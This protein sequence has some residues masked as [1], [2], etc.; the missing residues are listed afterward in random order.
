MVMNPRKIVFRVDAS[1]EIGTGHVMRCLTL[2]EALRDRGCESTFICR[3]HPGN[4]IDLISERGF[5][6]LGLPAV[7]VTQDLGHELNLPAHA[8]WLGADW[9]TDAAQT[10]MAMGDITADWLVIDHYA[11]DERWERE[12]RPACRRLMVIDDL[13]DRNHD[14]DL[15]LDQNLIEGWQDRYRGNVPENCALLLG[16][17]YALMQPVYSEL[18]DR[19]PPRE[20]PIQRILVYFGG[21]DTDNLT[22]MVISAFETLK[23]EQVSMDVVINPASPHAEPLRKLASRDGRIRL[24]EH[25]PSLAHLMAK[26][27]FAVGAGGA[28]SW[29][30]CCLGLPSI[31]ITLAENQ[32]P[33]AAEL[34]KL[35]LIQWLGHK[36]EVDEHAMAEALK[37]LMKNGLESGWSERCGHAVDGKGTSRVSSI[38][39]V[40][41]KNSLRARPATMDD[42]INVI[43]WSYFLSTCSHASIQNIHHSIE[44]TKKFRKYLRDIDT[45]HVLIVETSSKIPV[46]LIYFSRQETSWSIQIFHA[47]HLGNFIRAEMILEEALR[48]LRENAAGVLIFSGMQNSSMS[49]TTVANRHGQ[50]TNATKQKRLEI[51]VCTD[52]GSWINASVPTLIQGW[53]AEGHSVSWSHDASTLAGG[54]LCFNLSYGRIVDAKTRSRY[55]NNLVVHASDLPKGRG[56]SPASW[57]ILEGAERLPV[58]LLE[59][60]DA[61]DAGPIYLQK[62][63]PL[64]GA[65]LIDDWRELIADATIEL[66]RSFVSRHPEILH[67]AREQTGESSSYPRRRATNS[68]LDPA[69]TLAEQFN[70]LRIVDNEDYPAFFKH[71]GQEFILKICRRP[72]CRGKNS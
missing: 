59:A 10:R 43:R 18:H 62:W 29:E 42:E 52:R 45:Y 21:A 20:G 48:V 64:H 58:T 19:L 72:S 7:D 66:A 49:P 68:E 47:P 56:W 44:I 5:T 36:N 6:A 13:A 70:H 30:R 25:L 14:C 69:K 65:E 51:A 11:I 9:R 32:R 41:D 55:S 50:Y 60:V 33:I 53:L 8:A 15:L 46:S 61:V 17:E 35:R 2:A 54:D 71:K 38:L 63:I 67:E 37:S 24:H 39:V 40:G 22:G 16:P 31:V 3:E 12:L 1:L 4:L 27:D 23:S 57:L 26:A 28:T 34:H